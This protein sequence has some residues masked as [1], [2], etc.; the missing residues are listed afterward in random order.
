MARGERYATATYFVIDPR[1]LVARWASAGH[2]PA[3]VV[4]AVGT[5]RFLEGRGGPPLGCPPGAWPEHTLELAP[6][7]TIVLYTDGVVERRG[8]GLDEGMRMLAAAAAAVSRAGADA[9]GLADGLIDLGRP[10]EDDA[11]L[12]V[13]R[14]TSTP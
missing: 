12:V 8:A 10:E 4:P 14:V 6:G 2:L 11:C 3:L 13:L 5:P 9:D 7:D 1:T